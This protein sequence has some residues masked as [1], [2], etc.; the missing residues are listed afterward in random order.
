MS[1]TNY[2][3]PAASRESLVEVPH[4]GAPSP[5]SQRVRSL[6]LPSQQSGGGSR[7]G[8]LAWAL[9]LLFAGSTAVLGYLLA[10]QKPQA[11][12]AAPQEGDPSAS[13]LPAGAPAPGSSGEIALQGKGYVIPA[14]QILVS[15]KVTGEIVELNI[16]EGRKVEA[17]A[18]LAKL[19]PSE[20]QAEVVRAKSA[21]DASKL[22]WE[23]LKRTLPEEQIQV[24]KEL[25][26]A[27]AQLTQLKQAHE[28]N[29]KLR[30]ASSAYVSDQD[31][32]ESE[33][34][35]RAMDRRVERLASVAKLT[36][37]GTREKTILAAEADV[38]RAE[39][40]LAKAQLRLDYCTIK[41]P[42]SG[43]ILKKNAEI[44]NLVN[45]VAFVGSTS[46]CDMADLSKLEIEVSVQERDLHSVH[47]GQKCQVW[48]EAF[49]DRKYTGRAR[50][51]PIADRGKGS[52]WVR[53]EVL[54][55]PKE[56]EGVYLKPD[57]GA[58]VIFWKDTKDDSKT[59]Q[60][61]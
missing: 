14:H 56:E 32:E 54:D 19:E 44:G 37:D 4:D 10:T 41:A 8:R 39:A 46:L 12:E 48:A 55:I 59:T 45:P 11:T 30:E 28:R 7:T 60:E 52:V 29:L 33:S 35:Y 27:Q 61:R 18:I 15:P 51:M 24:R 57:M 1:D 53:V 40:E 36:T 34:R 42:I 25:E 16:V 23:E 50:L 26:E 58:M 5:L 17:G 38:R 9:S 21:L 31:V 22:K 6:R 47:T 13:G 2:V 20:Y 49:P 3:T 43:T